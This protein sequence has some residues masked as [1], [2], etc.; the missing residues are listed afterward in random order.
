M[1]KKRFYILL[2]M[3]IL[4]SL[5]LSS[6]EKINYT[7]NKAEAQIENEKPSTGGTLI[8]G[9]VEPKEINPL[10]VNSKS[11][12]DASRLLFEPLAEYDSSLKLVP[13]IAQNWGFTENTS[14]FTINLKND[15]FWSDGEKITSSDV[16]FSFDTI[17]ASQTSAFKE[18]LQHVYSY[19]AENESTITVVFDQPYSNGLDVLTIPIIP[20]HSLMNNPNAMPAASGPYKISS[21]EK[22]KQMVLVPNEKW[23][24]LGSV[25]AD[26]NKPYIEKISIQFIND[27][28][29]FSTSF[30]AKELDVL[31]TQSYDW[32]KYSE[33]KDVKTY[34]YTSLDYDFIG[35][36]YNNSLFQDKAVRK[37]I[38]AAVNRK[39]II[40]KYLLGNAVLT[41]VPV[42]P[43]S[44]LYDGQAVNSTSSKVDAANILQQAGFMDDNKDKVLERKVDNRLQT[45]HFTLL[46]NSENDFR[47]KAAEEIKKNLEEVGFSVDLRTVTFDEMKNALATKQFDAVLTGYNLSPNQDLSFAFHSSQIASGRNFMSYSNL[48]M[49]NYLYQA[50]ATTNDDARKQMYAKIQQTFREEVPCISL[51]FRESAVVV[52]DK[53]KGEVV[54]DAVNP[55]K[56]IQNWFISKNKR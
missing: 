33:L 1:L 18:K 12:L 10:T 29:A 4:S 36:N 22:L 35:F 48:D 27:L 11:F 26:G 34:K 16:I 5:I 39:G 44:W 40:D 38:L 17:M 15:L 31:H 52:R 37:A 7:E 54:P 30:Q 32:E 19:K 28:D 13:V 25:K 20:Q 49:D 42:H 47:V 23:I 8:M 3:L 6:C 41:D 53:V 51:F 14:R 24:R 45:L 55:Y 43:N 9:S 2:V 46:T 50:Y 56:N 21:Y